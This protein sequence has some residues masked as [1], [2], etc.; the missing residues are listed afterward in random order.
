M[1]GIVTDI[2]RG[3]THDGPGIRTV[4][5]LKGCPLSCK[6][7]HNPECISPG[8]EVMR[9]PEK[10]IGCGM[11]ADGCF[12]GAQVICGKVMDTDAVMAE[13]LADRGYYK[14]GGGVTISGGEPMMQPGFTDSLIDACRACGIHTAVETSM[15]L[16][17]EEIFKKLDLI[18][19]DVKLM[20]DERHEKWCGA[21]FAKIREHI[22]AAAELGVPMLA[23]TPVVPGVNDDDATLSEI[24][25][26][27]RGIPAVYRYEL[28]PYH[29]LGIPKRRALSM[30]VTEFAA[31]TKQRMEELQKYAFLR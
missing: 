14:S 10:C 20:D 28:L 17:K 8:I 3:S 9:Y 27:L 4:V 19:F 22:L 1:R 6:W 29:P 2:E 13:I 18:M 11:C 7:C 23:R 15:I 24:S 12:A 16:Y 5:F 31:P 26:F 21:K 30:E 25:D